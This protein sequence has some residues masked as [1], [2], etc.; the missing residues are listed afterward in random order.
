LYRSPVFPWGWDHCGAS[1][2]GALKARDVESGRLNRTLEGRTGI[3]L[4]VGVFLDGATIISGTHDG[5]AKLRNAT[6]G[7]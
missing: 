1:F 7:N 6:T 3:V 4:C 2:D 5:T